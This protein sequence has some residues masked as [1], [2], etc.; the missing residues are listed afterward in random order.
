MT[1]D[2]TN[3]MLLLS[4]VDNTPVGAQEYS[5]GK[6]QREASSLAGQLEE[7]F[8]TMGVS[9]MQDDFACKLL[10]YTLILGSEL[11][12]LHKGLN[13]GIAIAQ[14]KLGIYGGCIPNV[15]LIPMLKHRIKE[16]ESAARINSEFESQPEKYVPWV[17]EIFNRYDIGRDEKKG[18]NKKAKK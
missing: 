10:A 17:Q 16:L 9:M 3:L 7:A 6:P 12:V 1:L 15:K 5:P 11:C 14:Q 13:A 8:N 2:V 4:N 18:K